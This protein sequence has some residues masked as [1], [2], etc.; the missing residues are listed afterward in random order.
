[1][2]VQQMSEHIIHLY[3]VFNNTLSEIPTRGDNAGCSYNMILKTSIVLGDFD[4]WCLMPLSAIFQLYHKWKKP[5]Y[6]ERITDHGQATG[7]LDHL[8][9]R[10]EC[11]LFVIFKS[12]REPMPL[13]KRHVQRHK[14]NQI[15]LLTPLVGN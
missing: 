5:E 13:L 15:Q 7:K 11:T 6:P 12:G 10:V 9:L 4:F 8:R 14:S 3:G 2:L 1:M